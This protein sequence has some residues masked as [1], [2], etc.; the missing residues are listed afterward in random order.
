MA[1]KLTDTIVD[2]LA[3]PATGNKITYDEGVKGFGIRVTAAGARSFILNYRTRSGLERRYT[4]GSRPDWKTIPAREEAKNLKK[5]IDVGADPMGVVAASRDAK[6]VADLCGRFETEH[7]SKKRDTTARDYRALIKNHILPALKSKKVAEVE[8]TDI[9]SLHRKISKTAPYLAN[10][11][12]AVLSK[13]FGLAIKWRWRTD[14]PAKGIERNDEQKRH[15]YLSPAELAKLTE[16]LAK[17]EDQQAANIIRLLLLTGA[18]RGEV[19]AA[20]WEQFDLTEG[21]WTKPGSTTKQKTMH[22]VPLSAPA[23]LLL[24]ELREKA[25]D[26]A[27]YVFPGRGADH[28]VEIKNEWRDVC[29]AAGIV[30]AETVGEKVVVTPSAR[31]HDLRHTYAS[32][33]ASAG[34]SLPI[35]GALLGHSQPATTA[36]YSHLMDDPLR[37]AT[38]RVGAIMT[39]KPEDKG[40]DIKEFKAG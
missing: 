10:R 31:I 28:R 13:M 17:Q 34:L 25:K 1:T 36:R 3:L 2:T 4:I 7:L 40:A 38:E 5:Q 20:K 33:L 21:V 18:R 32:V 39:A 15:R 16:A 29:I 26:D 27:V 24:T 6:T 11:T 19:Q 14:N 22:R 30:T 35:I 23:R 12:V 37:Q 8:F 9:D